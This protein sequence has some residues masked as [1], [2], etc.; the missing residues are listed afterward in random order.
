MA[1]EPFYQQLSAYLNAHGVTVS[2]TTWGAELR[3]AWE[4]WRVKHRPDTMPSVPSLS[5]AP[6]EVVNWIVARMNDQGNPAEREARRLRIAEHQLARQKRR[7]ASFDYQRKWLRLLVSTPAD[8][9][10]SGEFE[11]PGV[12][13]M[14]GL[15]KSFPSPTVEDLQI[16]NR[17]RINP[18][19]NQRVVPNE[20]PSVPTSV[21]AVRVG[22]S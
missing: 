10:P 1:V 12:G 16:E 7:T 21:R 22:I 5:N 4:A 19:V 15:Q 13:P 14:G 6:V 18:S 8:Q 2:A 17:G 9:L 20:L 3:A 11:R